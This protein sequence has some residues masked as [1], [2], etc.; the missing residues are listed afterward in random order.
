MGVIFYLSSLP[1]DAVPGRFGY[2]GH[3]LEYALLGILLLVALSG[4]TDAAGLLAASVM[5]ASAYGITDEVHQ[6]FVP[7]RMPELADWM[8]DTAGALAG[9]GLALVI[10]PRIAPWSARQREGRVSRPP[11]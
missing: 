8:V 5:I 1:G 9:A 6:A 10:L 4:R 11:G 2:L 7:G 3:F